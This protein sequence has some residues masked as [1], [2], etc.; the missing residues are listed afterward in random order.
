MRLLIKYPTRSRPDRYFAG[1]DSIFRN[2]S[3]PDLCSILVTLDEDDPTM[4]TRETLDLLE[5]Y[6]VT[7]IAGRSFSKINAFN[8]DLFHPQAPKDWQILMAF[9]DDMRVIEP[10]FDDLIRQHMDFLFPDTDGLIHYPDAD[11]R[12]AV[13][14]LYVAGRKYFNRDGHI[15]NPSYKSYWCDNHSMRVAQLRGKYHF[16]GLQIID[17]LCPGMGRLEKDP[18][19]LQQEPNWA[20]DEVTF[21]AFEERNFDLSPEEI[22][23]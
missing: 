17:H 12:D 8:R 5:R 1:L 10:A 13:P 2:L 7:A 22:A 11:A 23:V 20:E 15:Y 18:L 4:W 3:R 19:Y 16:T 6:P 9:S 14:V 21:H